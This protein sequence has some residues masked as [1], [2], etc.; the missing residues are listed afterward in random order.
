MS[1]TTTIITMFFNMKKLIDSTELTRPFEFY[2]ENCRHVLKL[3]YPMI[4]FCEN[5][6]YEFLKNIRDS[7]VK[8]NKTEYVINNIENY[9]YYKSCWQIINNNRIKNGNPQDRR[10]T[11]SYLLMGMFKPFAFNYANI[12]NF[13]NTTHYAWIDIGCNH[14]VKE[15]ATYAHLMLEN[16]NPKV[17]VCYVHYRSHNEL[18]NMHEYMRHGGPCGVISTAY[19]IEAEYVSQYYTSMFSIFY[20]K[21]YKGVGHTDETVMT[22]C[23][24]RYPEI[25]NIYYG[26]YGSVFINYHKPTQNINII[27]HCFIVNA[28]QNNKTELAIDAAQKI[29]DC[30]NNLDLNTSVYLKIVLEMKN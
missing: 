11:V 28:I 22:Y 7:E 14:I 1:K 25:F 24:D 12:N 19:T 2:K 30:N 26:D 9:E 15:L 6:T 10:N 17:S 20:E 27:V 23:Y 18:S 29:L 21:L 5:D 13:F 3:N 16:P 4:I 8:D